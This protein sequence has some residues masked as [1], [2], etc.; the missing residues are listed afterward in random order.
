M[1]NRQP[2]QLTDEQCNSTARFMRIMGFHVAHTIAA[3]RAAAESLARAAQPAV[4]RFGLAAKDLGHV[5][6]SLNLV[7]QAKK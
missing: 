2:D 6:H 7:R 5:V 4:Q 3:E 1:N